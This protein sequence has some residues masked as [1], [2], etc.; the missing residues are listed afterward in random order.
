MK[1]KK[2]DNIM[3]I[4]HWWNHC[5]INMMISTISHQL[6]RDGSNI[7]QLPT[8]TETK[9]KHKQSNNAKKKGSKQNQSN[10]DESIDIKI[11]STGID[12]MFNLSASRINDII[13]PQLVSLCEYYINYYRCFIKEYC[14]KFEKE[15][16]IAK[17]IDVKDLKLNKIAT[18]ALIQQLTNE[19]IKDRNNKN[20]YK[21]PPDCFSKL[22]WNIQSLESF[23][24]TLDKIFRQHLLSTIKRPISTH[25]I[26]LGPMLKQKKPIAMIAD[27]T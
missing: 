4:D 12:Q 27:E 9:G 18:T 6:I 17:G 14:N 19:Y 11:K 23:P 26:S 25:H 7:P 16:Q 22:D 13:Y 10:K 8:I 20:N 15:E 2:E 1:H 3:R 21:F 24:I 5:I